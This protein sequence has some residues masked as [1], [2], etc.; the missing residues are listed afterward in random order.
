MKSL[1]E[2]EIIAY[3][4]KRNIKFHPDTPPIMVEFIWNLFDIDHRETLQLEIAKA[5]QNGFDD[6]TKKNKSGRGK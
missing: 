4:V 3:F 6:S 5:A 2:K 1:L